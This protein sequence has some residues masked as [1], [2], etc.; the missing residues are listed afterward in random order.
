MFKFSYRCLGDVVFAKALGVRGVG[1][2]G[3]GGQP[4][5]EKTYGDQKFPA[6][7]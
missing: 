7:K 4:F 5:S 1:G 6:L 3:G 2:G